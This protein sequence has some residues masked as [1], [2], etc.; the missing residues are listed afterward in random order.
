MQ[1]SPPSHD[2]GPGSADG[3]EQSNYRTTLKPVWPTAWNAIGLA[4]SLPNSPQSRSPILANLST[5][6]I[7]SGNAPAPNH[8]TLRNLPSSFSR[9]PRSI[10]NLEWN[11]SPTFSPFVSIVIGLR[12]HG[13]CSREST[14]AVK[15][16]IFN[17]TLDPSFRSRPEQ[18]NHREAKPKPVACICNNANPAR[19]PQAASNANQSTVAAMATPLASRG[20]LQWNRCGWHAIQGNGPPTLAS[21]HCMISFHASQPFIVFLAALSSMPHFST[22][23]A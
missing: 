6:P 22:D 3:L 13:V 19:Y 14:T 20:M 15:C 8:N 9:W 17:S 7:P 1:Y 21:R 10:P 23:Q 2:H 16:S 12:S 4:P 11:N 5:D 18:S